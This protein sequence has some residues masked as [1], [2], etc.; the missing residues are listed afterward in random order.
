M[1]A[2]ELQERLQSLDTLL[3]DVMDRIC[4]TMDVYLRSLQSTTKDI[5]PPPQLA[6]LKQ[7]SVLR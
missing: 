6:T 4:N 7:L 2:D 5:A 1:N 3:Y